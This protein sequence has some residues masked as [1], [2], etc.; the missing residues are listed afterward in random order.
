[1]SSTTSL[2]N[3][4]HPRYKLAFLKAVEELQYTPHHHARMLKVKESDIV[5][6]VMIGATPGPVLTQLT[7]TLTRRIASAG[8]TPLVDYTG[9]PSPTAFTR[10]CERIQPVAVIAPGALLSPRIAKALKL[11]GT[12]CLLAF[13]D[14]P[15]KSIARL[16]FSQ[17]PIGE[18]AADFLVGLGRKR[19]LFFGPDDPRLADISHERLQGVR[20]VLDDRHLRTFTVPMELDGARDLILAAVRKKPLVDAVFAYNDEL[21]FIVL[22]ILR[23]AGIK[24]PNDLSVIG[25][26]NLN[27]AALTQPPLTTMDLGDVGGQMADHL[28]AMLEGTPRPTATVGLPTVIEREST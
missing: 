17:E 8:Y 12:R 6:I 20:R 15:G 28:L 11:N 5:L 16:R 27:F 13:G 18:A 2:V 3:E 24:V 23:E 7:D 21:A 26:D 14:G 19:V 4:S 1:M 10:A 22:Q 9:V 25:C